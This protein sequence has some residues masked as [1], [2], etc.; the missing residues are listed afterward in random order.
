MQLSVEVKLDPKLEKLAERLIEAVRDLV[1]VVA[2][3][4]GYRVVP[5]E[6]E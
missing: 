4:T 2:P 3:L 5:E 6:E 1:E